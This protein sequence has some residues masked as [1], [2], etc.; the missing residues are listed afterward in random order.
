LEIQHVLKQVTQ[1]PP[2]T[3]TDMASIWEPACI[4]SFTV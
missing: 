4:W 2:A 1:N 3:V